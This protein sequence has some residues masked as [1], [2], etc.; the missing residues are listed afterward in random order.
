M[1][2]GPIKSN[3]GLHVEQEE[4]G[5]VVEERQVPYTTALHA[6]LRGR[7]PYLVGPLARLNQNAEN[8]HPRAAGLWPTSHDAVRARL[9]WRSS[10]L[11][12]LAR[13]LE[14]VHALALAVD[15]LEYYRPPTQ[16]SIPVLP[17][18][19]V[20]GHGTEAPRGLCWHQYRMEADGTI[21]SARIVTPTNQNQA[22]I[23]ADLRVLAPQ[24][25]SIPDGQMAL[26]CNRF[27]RNFDACI[28]CSTHVLRIP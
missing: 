14:A 1:N 2:V 12:F 6:G 10:Y 27:V 9:L 3:K 13:G 22:T 5:Q 18:A 15:L 24:I 11:G 19:G 21:A 28:S 25:A 26:R 4:F 8:L 16:S 23:E 20:G 17:R 7:G